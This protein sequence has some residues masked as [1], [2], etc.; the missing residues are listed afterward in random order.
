[1]S[2]DIDLE[3][4]LSSVVHEHTGC[5]LYNAAVCILKY[6]T[7]CL[8]VLVDHVRMLISYNNKVKRRVFDA[9]T[10]YIHHSRYPTVVGVTLLSVYPGSIVTLACALIRQPTLS[11]RWPHALRVRLPYRL[12]VRA[13]TSRANTAA[14]ACYI[15]M[16]L[17]VFYCLRSWCLNP[18]SRRSAEK[19]F[20]L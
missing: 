13:G 10:S 3:L 8:E 11:R 19:C 7:K 9:K 20:T 17:L 5:Y 12:D 6:P 16:H 2:V 4:E 18:W 15:C 1:M 14:A